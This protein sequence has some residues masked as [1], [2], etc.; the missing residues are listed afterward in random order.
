MADRHN[1]KYRANKDLMIEVEA[2]SQ[3]ELFE[4]LAEA[5]E[6]FGEHW[7]CC[8]KCKDAT[9]RPR[10]VVRKNSKNQK[11][12]EL[13]CTK[14]GCRARFVFGQTQDTPTLFPQRKFP[15]ND[16]KAGE[17]KPNNGWTVWT[18]EEGDDE[19]DGH[20]P[21]PTPTPQPPAETKKGGKK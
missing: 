12:Y 18:P 17:Y 15:K 16:P 13:H 7:E 9:H 3:K 4:R 21:T 11:F 8:G 19:G 20:E 1:A 5:A 2:T 14:P 10:P 6:V